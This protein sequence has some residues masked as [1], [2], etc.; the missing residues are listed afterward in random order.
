MQ[1]LGI[2][3][4]EG[5]QGAGIACFLVHQ[6]ASI[7]HKNHQGKTPLEIVTDAH[8]H[9]VLTQFAVNRLVKM[10]VK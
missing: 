7:T 5:Q 3:E 6:G 10:S 9:T 8:L 1:R 2:P 4:A